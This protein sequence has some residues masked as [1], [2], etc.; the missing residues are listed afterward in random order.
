M[1]SPASAIR[2]PKIPLLPLWEQGAGGMLTGVGFWGS[3]C[4]PSF[5]SGIRMPKIPLL[6]LWEKGGRGD[7]GQ[8]RTGMQQTAHRS[9]ELY[10]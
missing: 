3:P 2:T 10:P 8:T 4:V 9:Q 6:P 7:E 1:P 5:V